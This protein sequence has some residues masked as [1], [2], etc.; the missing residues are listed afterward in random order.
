MEKSTSRRK[1]MT[2]SYLNNIVLGRVSLTMIATRIKLPSTNGIVLQ[3]L[4]KKW[5]RRGWVVNLKLRKRSSTIELRN[6]DY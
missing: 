1:R 2:F 3:R 6:P 4:K 5:Q